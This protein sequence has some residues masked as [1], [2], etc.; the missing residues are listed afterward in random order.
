MFEQ[1]S[2]MIFYS[3]DIVIILIFE[4]SELE[5]FDNYLQYFENLVGIQITKRSNCNDSF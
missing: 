4:S 3:L 1:A 5:K 2:N